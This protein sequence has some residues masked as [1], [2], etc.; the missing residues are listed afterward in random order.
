MSMP[1]ILVPK[2]GFMMTVSTLCANWEGSSS[3]TLQRTNSIWSSSSNSRAFSWA[4]SRAS[5]SMSSPI[6]YLPPPPITVIF[7]VP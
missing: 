2:G 4:T 7:T 5:S 3:A 1:L 6:V